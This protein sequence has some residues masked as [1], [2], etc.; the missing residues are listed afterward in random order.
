MKYGG[1]TFEKHEKLIQVSL[2]LIVCKWYY[3]KKWT[4]AKKF[5]LEE[6]CSTVHAV[7]KCHALQQLHVL[8]GYLMLRMCKFHYKTTMGKH[9]MVTWNAAMAWQLCTVDRGRAIAWLQDGATL[10]NVAQT[11]NVSQSIFGRLWIRLL[12]TGNLTNRPRSERP[13]STTQWEDRYLTKWT[14][15]Q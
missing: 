11:L 10:Q 14:L 5:H 2:F 8:H 6:L 3:C 9:V 7:C 1:N 13:R 4:N 15:R 12:N